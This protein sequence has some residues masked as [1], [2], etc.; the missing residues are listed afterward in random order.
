MHRSVD[1]T[2]LMVV[3]ER[4]DQ[5]DSLTA[6]DSDAPSG[7]TRQLAIMAVMEP[8]WASTRSVKVDHLELTDR[9]IP[10]AL[11]PLSSPKRPSSHRASTTV[12]PCL[13]SMAAHL[14]S[15]QSGA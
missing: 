7:C 1:A 13:R 9:A 12:S 4:L 3:F 2:G 11:P 6:H 10:I 14:S 15:V 5:V 8:R